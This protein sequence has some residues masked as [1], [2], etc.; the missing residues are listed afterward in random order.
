[1]KVEKSPQMVAMKSARPTMTWKA[2]ILLEDSSEGAPG[3]A[4]G[5][6]GASFYKASTVPY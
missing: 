2:T 5:R 6:L 3:L 4:L 1:M